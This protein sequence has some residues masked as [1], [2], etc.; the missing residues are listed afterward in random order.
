MDGYEHHIKEGRLDKLGTF[1]KGVISIA[2]KSIVPW[3]QKWATNWAK[4]ERGQKVD[5]DSEYSFPKLAAI[6]PVKTGSLQ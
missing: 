3:K 4:E 1:S 6:S 5:R 2:P